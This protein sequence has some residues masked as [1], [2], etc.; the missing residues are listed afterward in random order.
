[1]MREISDLVFLLLFQNGIK[2]MFEN[3]E[4]LVNKERFQKDL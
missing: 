3:I 2:T 4:C 1:M